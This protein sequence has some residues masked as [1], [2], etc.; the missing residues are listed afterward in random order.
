[1]KKKNIKLIFLEIS[2]VDQL[3]DLV[4][5]DFLL[6]FFGPVV[7]PIFYHQ[8]FIKL[9]SAKKQKVKCLLKFLIN[10]KSFRF[11]FKLPQQSS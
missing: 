6:I 9:S 3:F 10:N 4:F 1:M 11:T 8:T 7:N 2:Y 5:L